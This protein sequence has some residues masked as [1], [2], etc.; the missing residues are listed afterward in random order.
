MKA[1]LF[2]RKVKFQW[3]EKKDTEKFKRAF[4]LV[5]VFGI[6]LK[7]SNVEILWWWAWALSNFL[8]MIIEN[9]NNFL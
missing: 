7:S 5:Q 2:P 1:W 9:L 3:F 8:W 6:F 4:K